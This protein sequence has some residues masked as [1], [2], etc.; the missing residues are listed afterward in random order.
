MAISYTF[1]AD[2][3]L[4]ALRGVTLTDGRL[5]WIPDGP[6]TRFGAQ[7]G[8]AVLFETTLIAGRSELVVKLDGRPDLA[9]T[10]RADIARADA[11]AQA[12]RATKEAA[13]EAAVPGILEIMEIANAAECEAERYQREHAAMM[14][15][16]DNDGLRHPAPEDRSHAA[17][18]AALL[19]A[20]PRA[21][22]YMT[23]RRQRQDAGW[24]DCDGSGAA[25][26]RAMELLAAG[27]SM[28]EAA[29]ALEHR[30]EWID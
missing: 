5:T 8:N 20:N 3:P 19:A 23:A 24:G 10:V 6:K 26:D 29:E 13:L 18:L 14:A 27:V 22:L 9:E 11:E 15:D 17:R 25:G 2:C 28:E 7:I 30:R 21:A 4:P 12:A 1:P 16:G